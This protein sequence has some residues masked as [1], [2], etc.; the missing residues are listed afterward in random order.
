[1]LVKRYTLITI[2]NTKFNRLIHSLDDTVM[3]MLNY[4][5]L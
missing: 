5:I 2:R 3:S 1:M 4:P